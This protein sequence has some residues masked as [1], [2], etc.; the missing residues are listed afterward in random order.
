MSWIYL[1]FLQYHDGSRGDTS[2]SFRFAA[3]FPGVLQGIVGGVG[4]G[5]WN[6]FGGV[7][8]GLRGEVVVDGDGG[9]GGIMDKG[10]AERRRRR[11]NGVLEERLRS[12][13]GGESGEGEGMDKV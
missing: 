2:E 8:G 11:A 10:D 3:C 6:V 9:D 7:F 4:E 1:R 5:C 12:Q 13:G